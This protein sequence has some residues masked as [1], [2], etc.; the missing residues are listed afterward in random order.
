MVYKSKVDAVYYGSIVFTLG[1]LIYAFYSEGM[2]TSSAEFPLFLAV[3]FLILFLFVW[4]AYTMK[5]RCGFV[6]WNIPR[7]DI[8][9]IKPS[10]SLLSGP[11]LS[12]DRLKI[13]YA[14]KGTI[15]ISPREKDAFLRA[16]GFSG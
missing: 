5:I 7:K 15:L 13:S 10:R 3:A 2:D 8:H 14:G 4:F 6:S 9:S 12:M 1:I 16:L 11:A